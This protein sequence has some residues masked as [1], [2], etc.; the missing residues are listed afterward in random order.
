MEKLRFQNKFTYEIIADESIDEDFV[1]VPPMLIQPYVE[2]AIWHGLMQ[3]ETPGHLCITL[4]LISEDLIKVVIEDNGIGREKAAKLK[5]KTAVT[6]K[7]F[8]LQISKDRIRIV[9][10][11]YGVNT[12]VEVEDLRDENNE[13]TGTRI[14]LFIPI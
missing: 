5:S 2:N 6:H 12:Q 8:G 4:V 3:K 14:N 11:L 13:A 1:Q 9:N 10:K 7:S